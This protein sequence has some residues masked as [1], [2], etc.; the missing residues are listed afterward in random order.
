MAKDYTRYA[1]KQ[2]TVVNE[3]EVDWLQK[4]T[5]VNFNDQDE[6]ARVVQ[7]AIALHGDFQKSDEN[8]AAKADKQ[9][10]NAQEAE[11]VKAEKAKKREADKQAKDE[12][13]KAEKAAAGDDSDDDDGDEKPA[14]KKSKSKASAEAPF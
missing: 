5:G 11:R 8:A 9:E 1:D 10:R 6:A 13:K 3:A 7:L 4:V 12:A 14:A 2:P